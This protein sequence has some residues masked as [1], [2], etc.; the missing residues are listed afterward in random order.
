MDAGA[1]STKGPISR[2]HDRGRRTRTHAIQRPESK[3][4]SPVLAE[5]DHFGFERGL[6]RRGQGHARADRRMLTESAD[7]RHQ[8]GNGLHLTPDGEDRTS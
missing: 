3:H 7:F 6:S 5:P 4:P 1:A 8:A 2:K